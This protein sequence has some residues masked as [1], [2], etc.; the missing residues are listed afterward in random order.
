MGKIIP[1]E[2]TYVRVRKTLETPRMIQITIER[3]RGEKDD[4]LLAEADKADRQ[5]T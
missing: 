2:W 1:H 5:Y 4:A 3:L